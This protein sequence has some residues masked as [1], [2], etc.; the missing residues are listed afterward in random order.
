MSWI[1]G[2]QLNDEW[3]S[4]ASAGMKHPRLCAENKYSICV[5]DKYIITYKPWNTVNAKITLNM[6]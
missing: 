6:A 1:K 2:T 3:D 5:Q 4:Q